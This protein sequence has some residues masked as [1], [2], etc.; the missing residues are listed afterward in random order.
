MLDGNKNKKQNKT[1]KAVSSYFHT[2]SLSDKKMNYWGGAE[3]TDGPTQRD[4]DAVTS[5][6]TD[7][8]QKTHSDEHM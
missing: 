1:K 6:Q 2:S 8:E 5:T 4:K 7:G 3:A